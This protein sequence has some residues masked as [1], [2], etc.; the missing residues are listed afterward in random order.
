MLKLNILRVLRL[1]GVEDASTYL[2]RLGY[3]RTK[4]YNLAHSKKSSIDFHDMEVLCKQLN[5]TPNDLMEWSPSK[6]EDDVP[7]HALQSIRRKDAAV[8]LVSLVQ[9]L[10]VEEMAEIEKIILERAKR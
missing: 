3:H 1:K 5:C 9:S 2:K 10:P 7:N 6:A 8:G 4:A